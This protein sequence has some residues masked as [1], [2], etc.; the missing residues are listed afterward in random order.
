M[1]RGILEDAVVDSAIAGGIS[2]REAVKIVDFVIDSWK[3]ALSR[4]E[5]VEMP[6]GKLHVIKWPE[7]RRLLQSKGAMKR[8]LF[9]I[10]RLPFSVKLT[11]VMRLD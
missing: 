2:H 4:H 10:Y 11:D 3:A 8:T 6:V 7:P 5:D 9:V 1:G